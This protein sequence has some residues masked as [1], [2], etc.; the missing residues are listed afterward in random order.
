MPQAFNFGGLTIYNSH[1]FLTKL[2]MV[3]GFRL[4][5]SNPIVDED[6]PPGPVL[7]QALQHFPADFVVILQVEFQGTILDCLRVSSLGF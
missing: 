3:Y 4:T 1:Q 6:S 2:G 5:P 7:H